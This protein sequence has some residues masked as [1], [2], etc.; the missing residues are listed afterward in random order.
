MGDGSPPPPTSE[1]PPTPPDGYGVPSPGGSTAGTPS[2]GEPGAPVLSVVVPAHNEAELLE[3]AVDGL[4]AGLR[5]HRRPFEV[6]VCENGSSDATVEVATRLAAR[7]R[8]VTLLRL[9]RAD[10]GLALRAGFAAALGE[11]VANVDVD[12]VDLGFLEQAEEM[13]SADPHLT[14]VVGTKR[15]AGA[16][17]R[18]GVT[19]RAVTWGF[20]V[21]MRLGFGLRTSDTHGLKLLRRAPL[22]PI[23]ASCATTA[24]L[25]DTELV[26]RAERAGLRIAEVP[27]TTTELRPARTPLLR[28]VARSV[29]DLARLRVRLWRRS[30]PPP[31]PPGEGAPRA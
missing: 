16:D 17:D 12:L 22:V 25:F 3:S 29:V 23:V 30:P 27:V 2:S 9:G 18:R 15:A 10:Y 20:A 5:R 6:L 4:V 28:R 14:V 11:T 24:S 8:E 13:L 26:L 19:R 7:Y 31:L 21:V 1:E